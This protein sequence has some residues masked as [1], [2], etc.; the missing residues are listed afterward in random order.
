MSILLGEMSEMEA[1]W[2]GLFFLTPHLEMRMKKIALGYPVLFSSSFK[3]S[4]LVGDE[5]G[6]KKKEDDMIEKKGIHEYK[7]LCERRAQ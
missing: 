6:E 2:L 7:I 3:E 5:S 4:S 1:L